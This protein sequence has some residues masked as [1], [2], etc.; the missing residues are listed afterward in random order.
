MEF[1][2][3][4]RSLSNRKK[5]QYMHKAQ[6]IRLNEYFKTSHRYITSLF[7]PDFFLVEPGVY[8]IYQGIG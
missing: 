7:R 2:A 5:L 1:K 6:K 4:N 8:S 3:F